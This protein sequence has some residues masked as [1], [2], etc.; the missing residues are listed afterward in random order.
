MH[1]DHEHGRILVEDRLGSVSVVDVPVDYGHASHPEGRLGVA[2]GDGDAVEDAEPHA[3]VG[4]RVMSGRADQRIHVVHRAGD[5]RLDRADGPACRQLGDLKP[6]ASEPG[7]PVA[8]VTA[9]VGAQ[10]L[11]PGHVRGCVHGQQLL[12]GGRTR[13]HVGRSRRSSLTC[14]R[15]WKRRLVAMLSTWASGSSQPPA[16]RYPAALP[17]SCHR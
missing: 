3:A 7:R 2:D 17:V 5:D 16:S 14:T 9:A 11:D 4:Q 13:G 1:R 10:L 15:F 8:R 12:P 6:A